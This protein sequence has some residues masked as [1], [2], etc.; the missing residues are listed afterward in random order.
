MLR[1]SFFQFYEASNSLESLSKNMLLLLLQD[2]FL[3]DK[4][5]LALPGGFKKIRNSF[6][7]GSILKNC[8]KAL[9][10]IS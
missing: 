10:L 8:K 2:V 4:K 7:L 1:E 3:Y 9:F 6:F 5:S